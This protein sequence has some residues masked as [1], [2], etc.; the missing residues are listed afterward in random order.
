MD[1]FLKSL[2]LKEIG[3]L[4]VSVDQFI[5]LFN[6]DEAIL[7]DVRFPIETRLWGM[8]FAL[9]IPSNELPDRLAELPKEKIIVCACPLDVRSNLTCQYLLQK[10]YR[11]RIL[12]GG[13]LALADRLRG[14][15]ASDLKL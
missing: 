3:S 13:L 14:G 1:D 9:E 10:G 4:L 6:S 12:T 5:N 11:A 15:A 7:L 2:T 8:H